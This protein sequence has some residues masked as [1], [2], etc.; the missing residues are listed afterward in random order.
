MTDG[1]RTSRWLVSQDCLSGSVTSQAS[2]RVELVDQPS[3]NAAN[4]TLIEWGNSQPRAGRTLID[5][6][7]IQNSIR[8]IL[9]E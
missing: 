8:S 4:Q 5:E 1:T 3:V 9:G 6:L 2:I 7:L